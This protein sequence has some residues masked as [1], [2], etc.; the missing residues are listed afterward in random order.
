MKKFASLSAVAVAFALSA[1]AASAQE[2]T[3]PAPD[4]PA[5][6]QAGAQVTVANLNWLDAR[7]YLDDNGLLVPLGFVVSQQ[8]VDLPLPTRA[9]TA[10]GRL[11][12]VARPIGSRET[13]VSDNLLIGRGDALLVT[14]HNQLGLSSTSVLPTI[15]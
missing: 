3:E 2:P 15:E 4:K 13:Y 5:V 7:I 8:T 14:L 10:T 1:A 9:L 12:I 11:R 6:R